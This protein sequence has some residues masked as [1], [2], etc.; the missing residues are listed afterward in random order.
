LSV[1]TQYPEVCSPPSTPTLQ[2][3]Y[4][5]VSVAATPFVDTRSYPH[6]GTVADPLADSDIQ[7]EVTNLIAQN[8]ILPNLNTEFF[9]F[10]G[11]N[12]NECQPGGQSCTYNTFC[13]Y[14]GDFQQNGDTVIY[15]YMPNLTS[16]Q[17]CTET[18]ASGPNQLAAD[19][20][21]IAASHEFAESITDP[22]VDDGPLGWYDNTNGEVGD[23][24]LPWV[25]P[26]GL[27]NL[28]AD[29]SN[30][31]SNGHDY[32]VQEL[33]SNYDAACVL[34][35]QAWTGATAE[36]EMT[37]GSGTLPADAQ[38]QVN[39]QTQAQIIYGGLLHPGGQVEW[40]SFSTTTRVLPWFTSDPVSSGVMALQ[41]LSISMSSPNASDQWPLSALDFKLRYPN[42]T[43]FCEQTGS[44][45]LGTVTPPV[46]GYD[47]GTIGF[48]TPN[49]Q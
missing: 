39:A 16:I 49:C 43:L 35:F 13:A 12:V 8:N 7:T 30:V 27:G 42:G 26:T 22:R 9:V 17:G 29:G 34:S 10:T 38:V 1:V 6:A 36:Y 5:T 11:A 21:I 47:T 41:A 19:R 15:A 2:P 33:W 45:T 37:T 4:G 23:I 14:H 40:S 18:I 20:E 28:A 44:G 24:C 3:C 48:A 46:G 31:T 25:S 32:V